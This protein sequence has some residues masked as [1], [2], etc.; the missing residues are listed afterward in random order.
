MSKGTGVDQKSGQW[1]RQLNTELE[2]SMAQQRRE[3]VDEWDRL[4]REVKLAVAPYLGKIKR[5]EELRKQFLSWLPED[6]DGDREGFADG[7]EMRILVSV[8]DFRSQ[9][10]LD[11]KRKLKKLWGAQKFLEECSIDMK[12]LPDPEDEKGLYSVKRRMG[13]R[14]LTAIPKP[15]QKEETAASQ[16][17]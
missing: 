4:D 3:M 8:C 12:Q 2:E 9:V 13:P 5:L 17:A 16:A 14:H 10:T 15:Q 1:W 7:V 11:G 6:M